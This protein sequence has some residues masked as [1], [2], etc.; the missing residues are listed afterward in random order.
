MNIKVFLID[1][2]KILIDSFI[3]HFKLSNGIEVTGYALSGCEA[4]E[5]LHPNE[6]AF[7]PDVVLQDIGLSDM[8]G[9]ECT[10]ALLKN[11]PNLKIIGVSSYMEP[12]IVKKL[13][14]AGAKGYVSKAT[15][16]AQL[17]EAIHQVYN[18]K[19]FLGSQIAKSLEAAATGVKKKIYGIIP[20]LT[21]REQEVLE[22]IAQEKNS[23]EIAEALF[24]SANTV[25]THRKNLILKFN[26]KN[27]VGLIRRAMELRLLGD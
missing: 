14:R 19:Q 9:I 5:M 1:D 22:Q 17:E 10:Q 23:K 11:N 8:N 3:D 27:S 25:E 21:E 2:H 18:G 26:V 20:E 12:S 7:P 13:L 4:I 16:I 15:D 24:I 6:I